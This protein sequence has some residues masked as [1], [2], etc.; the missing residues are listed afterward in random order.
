M[1]QQ[2]FSMASGS[3]S[4]R[5]CHLNEV[6]RPSCVSRDECRVG[7]CE[8]EA[9]GEEGGSSNRVERVWSFRMLRRPFPD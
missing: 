3:L 5:R 8:D 4:D 9:D 6:P 2:T 1:N 7:G